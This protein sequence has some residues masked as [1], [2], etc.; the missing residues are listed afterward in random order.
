MLITSRNFDNI[1]RYAQYS[2]S[3][4]LQNSFA[5]FIV[6]LD[7][8]LMDGIHLAHKLTSLNLPCAH[9]TKSLTK[10]DFK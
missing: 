5:L 2:H 8:V 3:T 1:L 6:N 4:I 9:N 10:I 7:D